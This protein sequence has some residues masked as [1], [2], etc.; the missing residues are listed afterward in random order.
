[1]RQRMSSLTTLGAVMFV[2]M[3]TLMTPA[4][5][6]NDAERG[7][8]LVEK[9]AICADCHSPRNERG[10]FDLAKWLQGSQ[11]DFQPAHPMPVWAS[12][13]PPL[14]GLPGM[15]E[16]IVVR[17]LETGQWRDSRPLRPPMPQYRMSHEDAV[18]I[19]AYL[20]SP[21]ASGQ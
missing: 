8:Y 9:V 13:A 18:A 10:E 20:K 16:A 6:R 21:R 1:M 19:A 4:C 11:L 5:A 7:R 2:A 14:A 15:D 17:L 12:Y 3:V